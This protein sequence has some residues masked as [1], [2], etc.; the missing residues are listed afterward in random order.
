MPIK[1]ILILLVA[2]TAAAICIMLK[3]KRENTERMYR[4]ASNIIRNEYIDYA[5]HNP[6]IASGGREPP[7]GKRP[8]IY[9]KVKGVKPVREYVFDPGNTVGIGRSRENNSIVLTEAIVSLEHCRI[10][11]S[12]GKV[13]LEDCG[14]ANGTIVKRGFH[15][16]SVYAGQ[17]L[18]LENGDSL[19]VG[20]VELLLKI[21]DYDMAWM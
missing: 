14:S 11:L 8:M 20:S 5:L 12:R 17:T 4:A 18:V 10:F 9:F 13:C 2:V 21:F 15:A 7:R 1:I 19:V 6:M 16:Y 3:K